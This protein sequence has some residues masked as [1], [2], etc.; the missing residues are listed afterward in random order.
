MA[1]TATPTAAA[2][3]CYTCT[4]TV[5]VMSGGGND[6]VCPHCGGGFIQA[7]DP[8][9]FSPEPLRRLESSRDGTGRARRSGLS[10]NPLII[11]RS[12]PDL[13][14]PPPDEG[15][16]RRSYEL[17]YED[18]VGSGLRPL[19]STM[20]E[21]LLGSG[22]QVML[23]RLSQVGFSLWSRPENPPASKKAVESLPVVE[24]LSTHVTSDSHCAV[25]IEA[26]SIGS[27]A[28]EMPCKHIYHSECILPWLS[29]RNS[30]PVCRY[31]LPTDG[32]DSSPGNAVGLTVW[33]LPGGGFA[34]GRF[35]GGGAVDMPAVYSE[36]DGDLSLS[37]GSRR[38]DELRPW[39]RRRAEGGRIRR[40]FDNFGSFFRRARS[41]SSSGSGNSFFRRYSLRRRRRELVS[42]E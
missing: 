41:D 3:W 19:P 32:H 34:V 23:D 25:C 30:C 2:Y 28:R 17:Y 31:Q 27:E 8:S 26:F 4:R 22:F 6:I 21:S 14:P 5:S 11:L 40:F 12:A 7:V 13:E 36:M 38:G 24:I 29:L 35:V 1:S 39:I 16:G 33:R 42:F 20:S 9:D 10:F 18:G 15:G 37:G